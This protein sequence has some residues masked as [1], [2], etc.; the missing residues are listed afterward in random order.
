MMVG[1]AFS[2]ADSHAEIKKS[3]T[4]DIKVPLL[5]QIWVNSKYPQY[6]VNDL[7]DFLNGWANTHLKVKR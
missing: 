7:R 4:P 1:C 3:I 6:R 2:F 5:N